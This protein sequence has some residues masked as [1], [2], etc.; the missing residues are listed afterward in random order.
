VARRT[1]WLVA[2]GVLLMLAMVVFVVV[3]EPQFPPVQTALVISPVSR[4]RATR[5]R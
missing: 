4:K 3:P 1:A 2:T 5:H